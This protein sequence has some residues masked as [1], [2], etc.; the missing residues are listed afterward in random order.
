[1]DNFVV[2]ERPTFVDYL[3]AGW[4]VSLT[5]AVDYTASNG[6]P[7]NPQSLHFMGPNNQ[8]ENALFN[9]GQVV[10]PYDSD[11]MF[12]V[13]GFGGIPR[14]MGINAVSHCFAMNGNMASPDINGIEQIVMTYRQT[15]P[16][17]GLGGPTLFGPL[18]T[19]FLR[20]L[21]ST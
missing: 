20:L 10:E 8:Y 17:I 11:K 3:R 9:V 16:Q 4:Q 14:H 21:Q 7:S 6:E 19:E 1:V 12:P 13:F 5:A 2:K 18:L 15:L